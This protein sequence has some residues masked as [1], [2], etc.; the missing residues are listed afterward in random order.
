M[1]GS[2][3]REAASRWGQRE[4]ASCEGTRITFG[5]L[6]D[7]VDAVASDMI[8]A[9]LRPGGRVLVQ[10]PNCLQV[11][12]LQ[13]A[14]WRA[15]AIAV[16]VVAIY[17]EHEL[18][19]IVN[20]VRPDVIATAARLGDRPLAAELDRVIAASSCEPKVRYVVDGQRDGWRAVPP[21]DVPVAALPEPGGPDDCCLILFTSGTTAAPKGARLSS[22]ALLAATQPWRSVGLDEADVGLAVAPLAHIAGMIPGCLVPLTIGCRV[23]IMVRWDAQ[24]AIDTIETER[25]TFSAGAA[26]FLRDLVERYERAGATGHRLAHFI[27]GGAATPPELVER[28]QAVG[29]GAS[30]AYGMTETAGVV[31][32]APADA[33]LSRRARYDGRLVDGMAVRV[34]DDAGVDQPPGTEGAIHIGGPQLLLGYTDPAATAAQLSGGWFDSG[35]VGLITEDGWLQITGRTK[36]IINRGGEKFSARDIEESILRHADVENAVVAPVPDDRLGE[37]VCAFVVAR[38]GAAP[39]TD[40]L[41]RFLLDAGMAKAKV[42]SEWHIVDRIPTTATGKVQKHLLLRERANSETLEE[43]HA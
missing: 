40:E 9:G 11:V 19:Q 21:P 43:A 16:P 26:V 15:G 34:L 35:D 17:R 4:Y 3:A 18:R 14:A 41:T 29:M 38:D 20:D 5:E 27:S 1:V 36:D 42:P 2:L 39:S 10:L 28:A 24:I 25:A 7:W 32:V 37:A 13:L 8:S 6:A 30:R 12:V 23:A 22:G 33:A 31:A